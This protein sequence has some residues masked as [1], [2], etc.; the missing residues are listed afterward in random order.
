MSSQSCFLYSIRS[1]LQLTR[2]RNAITTQDIKA[3]FKEYI[4]IPIS[5][6][7]IEEFVKEMDPDGQGF[8]SFGTLANE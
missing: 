7:D 2:N 6:D 5:E 4:D 8:I 1:S 3:V